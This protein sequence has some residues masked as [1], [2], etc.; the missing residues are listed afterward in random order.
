M[1]KKIFELNIDDVTKSIKSAEITI[2]IIG[3]E[4]IGLD[5]FA[6]KEA[7]LVFRSLGRKF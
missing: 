4:R 1:N 5:V 3:I 7:D 6:A 2:C